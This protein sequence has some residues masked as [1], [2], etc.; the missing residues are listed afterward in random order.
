VP[1]LFLVP[2]V[3]ALPNG[4]PLPQITLPPLLGI[5]NVKLSQFRYMNVGIFF[6]TLDSYVTPRGARPHTTGNIQVAQSKSKVT[7]LRTS[8]L[9]QSRHK[10]SYQEQNHDSEGPQSHN[11][12]PLVP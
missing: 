10:K 12:L 7:L 6:R 8:Q 5:K 4:S 11:S 1:Y 9:A 2:D 3:V